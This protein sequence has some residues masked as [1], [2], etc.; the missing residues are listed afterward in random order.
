ML[1]AHGRACQFSTGGSAPG[2]QRARDEV[3]DLG[4]TAS[5]HHAHNP[6][7]ATNTNSVGVP[8]CEPANVLHWPDTIG[9]GI[10]INKADLAA[11]RIRPHRILRVD[12][13]L[14]R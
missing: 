9:Y 3:V 13:T 6:D 4:R 14:E 8:A 11:V 1:R 12:Y 7:V 2:R 10:K 5:D